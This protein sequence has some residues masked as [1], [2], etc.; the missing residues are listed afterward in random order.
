MASRFLTTNFE[1]TQSLIETN[2]QNEDTLIN[3]YINM[4]VENKNNSRFVRSATYR[5]SGGINNM[6]NIKIMNNFQRY[7]PDGYEQPIFIPTTTATIVSTSNLA[8]AP[9]VS[10]TGAGTSIN[11]NLA[12]APPTSLTGAGTGGNVGLG[13]TS[14]PPPLL[15]GGNVGLGTTSAPPPLL[16]GG[17]VGLGTT[18]APP[19]LAGGNV[20]LG[21][22]SAPSPL[23]ADGNVGLGTTSAPPPQSFRNRETFQNYYNNYINGGFK[24]YYHI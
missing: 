17:N 16:A 2:P 19:P 4:I 13:T 11:S 7:G 9:P 6:P 21:T 24:E 10:L 5:D 18:S 15:A 8:N 23:L 12:N 22:T 3:D 14:A 20:G 1:N